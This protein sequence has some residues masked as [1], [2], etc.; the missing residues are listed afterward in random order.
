MAAASSFSC[1]PSP[2]GWGKQEV[3]SPPAAVVRAI[4]TRV[5]KTE[6]VTEADLSAAGHPHAGGE[7]WRRRG[8]S[9]WRIGPSPRGWGKRKAARD[10][11]AA[12]RAIPTR[13]GK[14]VGVMVGVISPSGHPH[15]GGENLSAPLG[16][17][18]LAGPS[19]RGWGKRHCVAGYCKLARAIPTRVGKTRA[20][21]GFTQAKPGH[22]H[23]GGENRNA[24]WPPFSVYGPSPRGWGKRD[25]Y[26]RY[27]R[28]LRAIPTRVGKTFIGWGRW[29]GGAGHPHA[30]G[31]NASRVP[32]WSA[33][34]GPSP[35]GWG[36]RLT[37]QTYPPVARAIPTRVGKTQRDRRQR[38]I[39]PGHPHAG[40][41]NR[42]NRG[43]AIRP[44]GPSPRGW[45]KPHRG[46]WHIC[47]SRAIPTRVG[48]TSR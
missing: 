6:Q 11:A 12:I 32:S 43:I 23:A 24:E 10:Q 2:R 29:G 18:P 48:K 30:G 37:A 47:A 36:K 22:P 44:A 5:G 28:Y 26:P 46:P 31:E 27:P 13:V 21:S 16:L 15:A 7:N 17:Q 45:G 40:G 41:E 20:T 35:R 38:P 9:L 39:D 19:P 34:R 8:L 14:T 25:C 1:G 4:P 42:S 33:L 3:V